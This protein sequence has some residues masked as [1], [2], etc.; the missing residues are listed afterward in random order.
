MKSSIKKEGKS[1][2]QKALELFQSKVGRIVTSQEL[3]QLTGQSGKP[4]SHNIRR[5]FELRD[6]RGYD[7]VNHNDNEKTGLNLKVNEWVL[8]SKNPDPKKNKAERR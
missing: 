1:Y 4:I 3:A 5:V 6:E 8:L 2:T 7:I